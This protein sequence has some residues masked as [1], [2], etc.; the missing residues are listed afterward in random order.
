MGVRR[1]KLNYLNCQINWFLG[2]SQIRMWKILIRIKMDDNWSVANWD[3]CFSISWKN[4]FLMHKNVSNFEG[5]Y[6]HITLYS[7]HLRM[8]LQWIFW[9]QKEVAIWVVIWLECWSQPPFSDFST[10]SDSTSVSAPL[11]PFLFPCF[12]QASSAVCLFS[13]PDWNHG[14]FLLISGMTKKRSR[15]CSHF[16]CKNRSNKKN[17]VR[18]KE[19][20][21]FSLEAT[22]NKYQH[23]R[24]M[25]I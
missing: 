9:E 24:K 2:S 8:N 17:L 14:K 16:C 21:Y 3:L 18:C 25:S 23:S 4:Q 19:I 15:F 20:G 7:F 11:H 5:N 10:C 22:W 6:S 1:W 13:F 12:A